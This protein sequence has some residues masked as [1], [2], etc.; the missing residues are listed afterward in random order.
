M[1]G[2]SDESG[3][4]GGHRGEGDFEQSS[5]SAT[6]TSILQRLHVISSVEN[7]SSENI[8]HESVNHLTHQGQAHETL[9]RRGVL[10][11]SNSSSSAATTVSVATGHTGRLLSGQ[12]NHF[13]T[14]AVREQACIQGAAQNRDQ[15]KDITP[16]TTI[17]KGLGFYGS[18]DSS[19]K[20][21]ARHFST[22]SSLSRVA[23]PAALISLV[24]A[25]TTASIPAPSS[26]PSLLLPSPGSAHVQTVLPSPTPG[27]FITTT[28]PLTSAPVIMIVSIAN[29]FLWLLQAVPSVIYW[30]ITMISI[31]IPTAVF[32]LFS[33]NL[34]FT[35]N[36]TTLLFITL[37]AAC[38][39]SWFVRYRF[40]NTYSR[41]PPEPQRKEPQIDLFPDSHEGD[42]KP[43][44]ANFLDEFLSAIKIFGYLERP[45]FHELT[46]MMQTKKLI[47]GETL[48]LE[49]EKGFCLVVDGTVQIFVKSLQ[50]RERESRK[51]KMGSVSSGG[52]FAMGSDDWA[53]DFDDEE[54][55]GET[56]LRDGGL[57]YQLL[58]EVK[59]GASMSSLFS[60]LSLFTEDVQLR[61]EDQS[62]S[63]EASP[64]PPP[65][66]T[67]LSNRQDMGSGNP[68][69]PEY[70]PQFSFPANCQH[71]LPSNQ[72]AKLRRSA[73]N[74]PESMSPLSMTA[75]ASECLHRAVD[76]DGSASRRV[77]I[78]ETP[79]SSADR[80]QP[81]RRAPPRPRHRRTNSV[82]PDIVAR[83]VVDTTIAIIPESAFRRLTRVYPKATA[84][85]IQVIL[86]RLQRVTFATAHSYL[87]LNTEVTNIER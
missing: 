15:D 51:G 75:N 26:T 13:D 71:N 41:L 77:V 29:A 17:K 31:S 24:A 37:T 58:T 57:G 85:I 20:R 72:L 61:H 80:P 66:A 18:K 67:G 42:S 79:P 64:P 83:A 81:R 25:T 47:A 21:S 38:L 45:V 84:H 74:R 10:S 43:G 4:D 69:F 9:L 22:V 53:V 60:I 6:T 48:L 33:T 87:G 73:G 8:H 78:D 12:L 52:V 49:E 39:V 11:S 14:A 36:F 28:S 23:I 32:A 2:I 70:D 76:D 50:E 46:R 82:H 7:A 34:T 65:P 35:M 44:L 27:V 19:G 68:S 5:A 1:D 59:N 3:H 16:A 56:A 54:E 30:V 55:E 86:T 62:S 63:A 40:L